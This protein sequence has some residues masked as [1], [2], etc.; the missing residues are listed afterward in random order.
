MPV[1]PRFQPSPLETAVF[2]LQ[3][4]LNAARK[5]EGRAAA[6]DALLAAVEFL[7]LISTPGEE[8]AS[9]QRPLNRLLAALIDLDNGIVSP[10]LEPSG[11]GGE[12]ADAE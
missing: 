12:A 8:A 9:I 1:A 7:S 10:L 5:L 4:K 2:A 3:D 6:I 11:A